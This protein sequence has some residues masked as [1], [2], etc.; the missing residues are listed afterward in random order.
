M[1]TNSAI[2][3][4]LRKAP[5]EA[6]TAHGRRFK[7]N[8]TPTTAS[9]GVLRRGT[10]PGRILQSSASQD[11]KP[12][13]VV[14]TK[15]AI[16]SR[17][18][19]GEPVRARGKA[20]IDDTIKATERA[21][22]YDSLRTQERRY[23]GKG[24]SPVH[25]TTSRGPWQRRN[26]EGGGSAKPSL[27]D[28]ASSFS[29]SS[30]VQLEPAAQSPNYPHSFKAGG[31]HSGHRGAWREE[32]DASLT[33]GTAPNGEASK[34]VHDYPDGRMGGYQ[35]PGERPS[36]E[37][38]PTYVTSGK[39][40]NRQGQ[41][42]RIPISVPYTT[43]ASEFLYGMSTTVAALKACQRRLYKLYLHPRAKAANGDYMSL[44]KLASAADV[45]V[46]EVGNDWLPIMD[47]MSEGRPH[48]VRYPS[49]R[50]DLLSNYLSFHFDW[51]ILMLHRAASSKLR[52][53]PG[54][55]STTCVKSL[56]EVR[57]S[58]LI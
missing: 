26:E 39:R 13:G 24:P 5:Q 37:R 35:A 36:T 42:S 51:V 40:D 11:T 9:A 34:N 58:S 50:L 16:A 57:L 18:K 46:K 15:G 22:R 17:T 27:R 44:K 53:C 23:K 54:C 7:R 31:R 25:D 49:P 47:K 55:Q 8:S 56:L 21:G 33:I 4:I 10:V 3:R 2:N 28:Q 38:P 1:S 6:K 32:I 29:G 43:S 45:Q 19:R 48:N 12:I 52:P 14:R 41:E 20:F 30:M